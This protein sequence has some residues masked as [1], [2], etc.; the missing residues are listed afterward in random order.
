MPDAH[1]TPE[2]A[3]AADAACVFTNLDTVTEAASGLFN[4]ALKPAAVTVEQLGYLVCI[5]GLPGVTVDD[6]AKRKCKDPADVRNALEQMEARGWLHALGE[7]DSPIAM[8]AFGQARLD[9]G[10]QLWEKVQARV[11]ETMGGE[12]EWKATLERLTLLHACLM[13]AR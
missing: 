8:T 13:S 6:L 9:D 10:A 4:E 12:E 11:V 1:V 5:Q 2:L 7:N 3:R